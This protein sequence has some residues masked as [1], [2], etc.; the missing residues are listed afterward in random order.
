MGLFMNAVYKAIP[1]LQELE[2][3]TEEVI[4]YYNDV[5]ATSKKIGDYIT[6]NKDAIIDRVEK[7]LAS[8]IGGMFKEIRDIKSD[9]AKNINLKPLIS[10]TILKPGT[11]S[12]IYGSKPAG[13][14]NGKYKTGS[15]Q[16][17]P[18]A[19]MPGNYQK[20]SAQPGIMPESKPESKPDAKPYKSMPK[21]SEQII[22]PKI[23]PEKPATIPGADKMVSG[24]DEKLK[25]YSAQKADANSVGEKIGEKTE[26]AADKPY[27]AS[28]D[29]LVN[30]FKKKL[31]TLNPGYEVK[32]DV[33]DKESVVKS[34]AAEQRI[35]IKPVEAQTKYH[36]LSIK[37]T[38]LYNKGYRTRDIIREAVK[39]GYEKI[40]SYND[41]ADLVVSGI[42]SG[43]SYVKSKYN[44]IVAAKLGAREQIINDYLSGKSY[45]EIKE[46]LKKNTN[47]MN[48]SDSTIL[49][50]MHQYEGETG[51]KVVGKRGGNSK[52]SSKG[53]SKAG[54]KS[55][56]KS[57]KK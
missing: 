21:V 36:D 15:S 4:G 44:N 22:P 30:D 19:S 54:S 51:K 18:T 13:K 52:K 3:K 41:V 47:G 25:D 34:Y 28:L 17:A 32:I 20:P 55:K 9:F 49:K 11:H 14:G 6:N 45:A 38:E 2:R 8:S 56:G 27:Q 23:T 1:G 31:K 53:S 43:I 29:D 12:S 7:S 24:L 42:K 39:Q 35:S 57:R 26:K 16:S 40:R 33:Y 5:V 50:I 10:P 46:N 48:I 37:V